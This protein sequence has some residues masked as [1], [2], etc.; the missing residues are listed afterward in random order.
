MYFFEN[1]KISK[2]LENLEHNPEN[3]IKIKIIRKV[4]QKTLEIFQ[5]TE[6]I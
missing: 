3:K 5:I 2:N 4:I 1:K 6:I